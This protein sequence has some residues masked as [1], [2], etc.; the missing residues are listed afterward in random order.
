MRCDAQVFAAAGFLSP[1]YRGG[2]VQAMV[3]PTP[4]KDR[5]SRRVSVVLRVLWQ[6]G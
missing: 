1:A 2:L 6:F 3:V 5:T 4:R